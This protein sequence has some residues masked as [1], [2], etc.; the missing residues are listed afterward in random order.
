MT[1]EE[2]YRLSLYEPLQTLKTTEEALIEEVYNTLEDK[3]YIRISYHSDK[4]IVFSRLLNISSRNIPQIKEIFWCEDTIVIEE[5]IEGKSLCDLL[6]ERA[7]TRNETFNIAT[8]L[9]NAIEVLH[10]SEI[11]HRDIK[12]GNI[13]ITENFRTVLIDYGI[14]RIFSSNHNK[15]TSCFGTEGFAAPEQ[16]GF[17]QS[18]YRSDIY[19]FGATLREM[20][21][22]GDYSEFETVISKCMEFDPKNRPNSASKVLHLLESHCRTKRKK[23]V[24]SILTIV[25]IVVLSGIYMYSF[26]HAKDDAVII[27]NNSVSVEPKNND[28]EINLPS[29]IIDIEN[30]VRNYLCIYVEESNIKEFEIDLGY[31]VGK[32]SIST[33]MDGSTLELVID[34][35]HLFEFVYDYDISTKSYENTSIIADIVIYDL[36]GDGN[37]EIIPVLSDAK[38]VDNNGQCILINGSEAWC[39]YSDSGFRCAN[40]QI[41]TSFDP[42]RI[43]EVEPNCIWGEF[44]SY[45]KLI[46]GELEY[47]E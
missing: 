36:D 8:Q 4:R 44:P 32:H 12:P 34:G 2:K 5:L 7:L 11:V 13:I 29:R 46:D 42:L 23:I 20:T 22:N 35:E 21:D 37:K 18:D 24:I 9:L 31:N 38:I 43:Y 33:K 45:Y 47:Y 19:A 10:K 40:G 25:L 39:I 41:K 14:A 28:Y 6:K 30:T 17:S 16:Y 27:K 3:K 15:D 1:E 26:N